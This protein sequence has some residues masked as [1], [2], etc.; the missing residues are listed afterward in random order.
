MLLL[1]NWG[2]LSNANP[3]QQAK[4]ERLTNQVLSLIQKKET[5]VQTALDNTWDRYNPILIGGDLFTMGYLVFEGVKAC[6]PATQ[7][8]LGVIISTMICGVVAGVINI[9][10]GLI[11]GKEAIQAFKNGDHFL[12]LRLLLDTIFCIAIGVVM[13]L[14]SLAAKVA[15]L[16]GIGAFFAANPWVLPVL[17]FVITI[18]LII[19]IGCRTSNIWLKKDLASKMHLDEVSELLKQ[20]TVDWD[21]LFSLFT[22][23]PFDLKKVIAETD[24]NKA[25]EALS[26]KM[27]ELQA[28]MG[29]T[30]AVASFKLLLQLIEHK[31]EDALAQMAL[32]KKELSSWNFAQHVRLFQQI[33]YIAAFGGSMAAL[34][35]KVNA[36]AMNATVNFSMAAANAIPLY[37]DAFWPFKRNT[38]MVVP[39]VEVEEMTKVSKATQGILGSAKVA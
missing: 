5:H 3:S 19:E 21:K 15:I 16:G 14:V 24:E 29:V 10:V 2:I 32:V 20:K 12:G 27:E 25:L 13:I 9:G 37:M 33:L 6:V 7:A 18:P 4:N 30:A 34:S 1:G 26:Q 31:Q 11:C 8:M 23:T 17:F 28:D 35:P 38:V 22:N 36:G 39:K